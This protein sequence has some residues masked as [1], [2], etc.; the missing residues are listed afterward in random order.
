MKKIIPEISIIVLF[1][2]LNMLAGCSYYHVNTLPVKSVDKTTLYNT[3]EPFARYSI[4]MSKI[5]SRPSRRGA[6]DYVFFI[7]VEGHQQDEPLAKA[8][9]ALEKS[10][11]MMKLLGSYPKGIG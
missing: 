2:F 7:D 5:E 8:L 11:L 4:S 3:L 9:D 6:W 1:A 10:V